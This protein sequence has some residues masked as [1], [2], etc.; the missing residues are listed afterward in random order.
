MKDMGM[1]GRGGHRA[2]FGQASDHYLD[3][4]RCMME[5]D[6]IKEVEILNWWESL[7]AKSWWQK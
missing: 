5:G 1:G 4:T 6:V 3:G 7:G 2:D